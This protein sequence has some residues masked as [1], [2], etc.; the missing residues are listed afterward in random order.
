MST[1]PER[2]AKPAK[3][4]TLLTVERKEQL[5]PGMVRIHFSGD[6]AAFEG[7]AF[8]DRYVKLVFGD[9]AE[10]ERGGRPTLRTYTAIA[11]DVAAGTLTIDFV[12]HGDEGI[13]GPWAAAAQPGD[14]IHVRGPGGAY[15]PDP[16]ADWHLLAGDEAALPAIR[17]ALAALPADAQ[18]YVVLQVDAAS[19][20][21]EVV[22][23]AGVEL[24]WLHRSDDTHPSL[25]AAVRALP[26]REGRVHA[27][28]HG[29]GQAVMK[30]IRPYLV[31]E[32]GV[33]RD[34]VSI[35]AYWKQGRTEETFR[36][37]KAALAAEEDAR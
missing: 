35:S 22:A 21:Q 33:P 29:E 9:V 5:T 19:Y 31:T 36:E 17:Q 27:F 16:A 23:P 7:S 6:L 32:R 24:T 12:V 34:D 10:L 25:S 14:T 37:W 15:A 3:P 4:I 2:P 11:P 1:T 13:A 20:E 30:E 18:G 26:W 28:V 8:T